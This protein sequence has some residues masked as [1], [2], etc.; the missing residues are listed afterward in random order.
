MG[1]DVHLLPLV[2]ILLSPKATA[3]KRRLVRVVEGARLESVYT[4]NR[5][6]GSNP[7]VSA[8]GRRSDLRRTQSAE[9]AKET[10]ARRTFR[11]GGIV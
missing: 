11:L 9:V 5:I 1:E 3:G 6:E 10:F 7:S 8:F 4:G 2:K